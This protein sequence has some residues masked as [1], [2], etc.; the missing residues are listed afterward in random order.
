[1]INKLMNLGRN[2]NKKKYSVEIIYLK[3]DDEIII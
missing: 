2:K 3:K 1:M